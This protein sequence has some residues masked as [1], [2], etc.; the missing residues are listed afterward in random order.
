MRSI[1]TGPLLTLEQKNRKLRLLN[2]AGHILTSTH[3]METLLARLLQIAAQ[4]IEAEGGSVWLWDKESE[5]RLVCRAAVHSGM[6]LNLIGAQ[7]ASG[8]GLVGWVAEMGESDIVVETADDGRF[9]QS[10][11]IKNNFTTRSLLAVPLRLQGNVIGVLEVVNKTEGIFS[12]DDVTIAETLASS[13]AIAIDNARLVAQLQQNVNDLQQ[14]NA[15]L[16][17][18]DHTVANDLQNPLALVLGFADLLYHDADNISDEQR[19]S[20]LSQ[21]II[22]TQRMSNIVAELLMLSSVRKS[23]VVQLPLSMGDIV[24]AALLRMGHMQAK[25][26]PEIILPESWPVALGHAPWIEEVWDNYIGNA[27]KYGGDPLVIE[28]GSTLLAN[29]RIQFWIRDNGDGIPPEKLDLLFTPFTRLNEVRVT[30]HGLGL[31]IVS[32]IMEKLGGQAWATSEVGKGSMFSF[33]LE[34]YSN[35]N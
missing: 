29:G 15:E 35:G 10:F 19:R 6:D 12:S 16:D 25:Y 31:S 21:L 23:D 30:G 28:L 32:R 34:A 17:A 4:L 24:D 11:D 33:T 1:E 5:G 27:M 7:V 22:H 8:Q 3:E 26:Q 2:R 13:A 9:N 18:F 14:R 20:S